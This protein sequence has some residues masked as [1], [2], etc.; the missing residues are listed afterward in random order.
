MRPQYVASIA[1]Q[2]VV[3][4]QLIINQLT[5]G[6]LRW[7]R[8]A[9]VRRIVR[10]QRLHPERHGSLASIISSRLSSETKI[11]EPSKILCNSNEMYDK[12]FKNVRF[13]EQ[14]T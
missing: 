13:W 12:I 10:R 14:H 7:G 6:Q 9:R 11:I 4:Q 5:R 3:Y 1:H 2:E 8:G